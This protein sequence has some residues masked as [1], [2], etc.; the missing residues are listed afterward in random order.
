VNN[1]LEAR[2]NG[3]FLA[4]F[5]KLSLHLPGGTEECQTWN[6]RCPGRDLNVGP[7]A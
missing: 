3:A 5:E 2:C 6:S 1:E 7:L 4:E